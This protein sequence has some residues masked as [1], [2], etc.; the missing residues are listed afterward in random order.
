MKRKR[1][2]LKEP[3]WLAFATVLLAVLVA[4][5]APVGATDATDAETGAD[6]GPSKFVLILD[7][8]GDSGNEIITGIDTRVL[9]PAD[10]GATITIVDTPGP[11]LA[12][13]CATTVVTVRDFPAGDLVTTL[14]PGDFN[15][16]CTPAMATMTFTVAEAIDGRIRVAYEVM[17]TDPDQTEFVND[18]S[19]DIAGEMAVVSA[20]D[21]LLAAG[22]QADDVLAATGINSSASVLILGSFTLLATGAYMFI[23]SMRRAEIA[24]VTLDR[25]NA[26]QGISGR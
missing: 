17:I 12:I 8:P 15:V 1:N 26:G 20:S 11:G 19:I 16:S 23:I 10:V 18:G 2:L 22:G 6:E 4:L 14:A 5:T 9:T 21:S 24:G 25:R 3:S 13:D 7:E